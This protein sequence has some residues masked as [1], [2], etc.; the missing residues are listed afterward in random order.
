MHNALHGRLALSHNCHLRKHGLRASRDIDTINIKA[1]F[2]RLDAISPRTEDRKVTKKPMD[3]DPAGQFPEDVL[4]R[5]TRGD[6]KGR[7]FGTPRNPRTPTVEEFNPRLVEVRAGDLADLIVARRHGILPEQAQRVA[8][9]SH[10]DL[11]RFR[12][13]D[14][15][16]ATQV[17][18]GLSLTGGHHRTTEIIHRVQASQLAPDTIIRILLHD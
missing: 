2:R 13:N 4:F 16:S 10:K 8:Q 15:I 9:L 5:I 1:T 3:A 17:Q 14:P 11:I 7:T 6:A 18:N 12:I